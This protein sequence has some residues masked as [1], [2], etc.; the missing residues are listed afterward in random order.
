MNFVSEFDEFVSKMMN[1]IFKTDIAWIVGGLGAGPLVTAWEYWH[2][3][4]LLDLVEESGKRAFDKIDDDG[5]GELDRE[6][7]GRLS[8]DLGKPLDE[9]ALDIFMAEVL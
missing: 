6:E 9:P 4:H 8:K 2:R 7:I 1:L 3:T 5:S